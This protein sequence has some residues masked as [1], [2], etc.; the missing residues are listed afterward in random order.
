[1]HNEENGLVFENGN[2]TELAEKLK[3]LIENK[4]LR[5]SLGDRG[6]EMSR[7]KY[8]EQIY[9]DCYKTMMVEVCGQ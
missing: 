5:Q 3:R 6:F 2:I 4:E 9:L 8:S 7:S 1:M